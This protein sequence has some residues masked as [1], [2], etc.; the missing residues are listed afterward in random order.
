MNRYLIMEKHW[1]NLPSASKAIYPVIGIHCDSKGIAFPSQE[2]IGVIAGCTAKT[3]R[4]GVKGLYGFPGLHVGHVITRKGKRSNRYNIK[5]ALTEKGETVWMYRAFFDGGHWRLIS[6]KSKAIYPVVLAF[7][8]FDLELYWDLIGTDEGPIENSEFFSDG[9]YEHRDFDIAEPEVDVLAE[10]AGVSK[11]S[12]TEA[13]EELEG[14]G[15]IAREDRYLK[16][17]RLPKTI[18]KREW[19]NETLRKLPTK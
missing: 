3:V 9:H 13:L 2:T 18:F 1:S 8:F 16:V 15:F 7:S 4:E 6:S 5:P 17:Y 14:K 19:I 10:Y 11:R 12:A